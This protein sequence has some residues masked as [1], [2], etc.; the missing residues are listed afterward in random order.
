MCICDYCEQDRKAR[1][2]KLKGLL[3][4]LAPPLKPEETLA[5]AAAIVLPILAILGALASWWVS[6]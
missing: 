2:A 6:Q 5:L 3:P 4:Q 1:D